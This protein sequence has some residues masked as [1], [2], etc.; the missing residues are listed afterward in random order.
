M[1]YGRRTM[2]IDGRWREG[3]KRETFPTLNPPNREVL[4]EVAR[5]TEADIDEAVDAARRALQSP[6]WYE[7]VPAARGRLLQHLISSL[8]TRD[9]KRL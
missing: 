3:A 8:P 6:A 5:G 9:W 7:M 2:L 4:A 1:R